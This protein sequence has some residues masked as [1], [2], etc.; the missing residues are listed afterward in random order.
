MLKKYTLTLV[1]CCAI[2]LLSCQKEISLDIP[3]GTISNPGIVNT[4]DIAG[5]WTFLNFTAKTL[6]IIETSDGTSTIK[7]VTTSNYTSE[8][9][10]GTFV[11][12]NN[13]MRYSNMAYSI[14]T[15]AKGLIYEDGVLTDS[16]NLPLQM[17]IPATNGEFAFTRVGSDSLSFPAGGGALGGSQATGPS[18][19]KIK[20][21]QNKLY[22]T[23]RVNQATSSNM[24]G[25]TIKE[26][27]QAEVVTIFQRL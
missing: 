24:Q 20:I 7:T 26:T 22:L 6:A 2:F 12:T 9:N 19:A 1:T 17:S 25:V 15:T 11:F 5:N 18:G 10:A 27:K 23:Q 16:I 8:N 21:E 13:N 4:V 3:T 14:N